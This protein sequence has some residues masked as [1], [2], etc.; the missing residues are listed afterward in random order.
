MNSALYS[1]FTMKKVE[2]N[3]FSTEYHSSQKPLQKKH[4]LDLSQYL[5]VLR[6]DEKNVY[7]LINLINI[8]D[9]L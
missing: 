9:Q 5:K 6:K 2:K 8:L 4:W 3:W 1:I 7:F